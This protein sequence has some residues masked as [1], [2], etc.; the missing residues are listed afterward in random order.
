[1]GILLF[2]QKFYSIIRDIREFLPFAEKLM[3]NQQCIFFIY[4]FEE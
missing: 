1:M 3:Y 2:L 4:F